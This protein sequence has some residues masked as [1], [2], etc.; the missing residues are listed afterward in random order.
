MMTRVTLFLLLCLI[1]CIYG[2]VDPS[3]IKTVHVIESNHLDVGFTDYIVNVVNV[4]NASFF[5]Y[6]IF[7]LL[8]FKEMM[9][10]CYNFRNIGIHISQK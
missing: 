3:T 1:S 7:L 9:I 4:C 2:Q 5:I 10:I 8:F 6:P